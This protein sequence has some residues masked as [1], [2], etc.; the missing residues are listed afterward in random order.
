MSSPPL[1]PNPGVKALQLY[2]LACDVAFK[3][4]EFHSV[5][6]PGKG[7]HATRDYMKALRTKA[8]Q[9]FGCDCSEKP[10]ARNTKH[11][12]DFYIKDEA[13]VVEVALSLRHPQSEYEKDIFKCLLATE[14]GTPINYLMFISKPGALSRLEAS[15]SKAIA[16]LV[17][18]HFNLRI[19]VWEI[20]RGLNIAAELRTMA[21]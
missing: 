11:R 12:F 3:T 18:K 6:G 8:R 15:G 4:P 21:L 17:E 9:V 1:T 10:V 5:K 14:E 7:D 19:D 20:T 2:C 16:A 13:T